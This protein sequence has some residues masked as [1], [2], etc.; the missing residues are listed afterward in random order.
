MTKN[1]VSAAGEAM[2]KIDRS[3]LMTRAWAIF[4]Q[5]Y[6][7][8]AIKF[9]DIGRRLLCLGSQAG[10]GRG[11][12]SHPC[13]RT[14]IGCQGGAHR[15]PSGP[16]HP[17]RLHR[18]WPAMEGHD[19]RPSRRNPPITVGLKGSCHAG[20]TVQSAAVKTSV[21]QLASLTGVVRLYCDPSNA[22]LRACKA[23]L[24]PARHQFF[25]VPY[26]R[27]IHRGPSQPEAP[28]RPDRPSPQ[29]QEFNQWPS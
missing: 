8:P 12:R 2:P 10:M 15:D 9:S 13:C 17:C 19:Q 23:A 4:C 3:A 11:P 22:R 6:R 7:Y 21:R 25:A 18:L 14:D 28:L 29:P 16:G 24:A 26:R 20:Q 5:T 1:T 27:S